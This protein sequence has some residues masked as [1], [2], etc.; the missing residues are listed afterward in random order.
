MDMPPAQRVL[1]LGAS[2]M[3]GRAVQEEACRADEL[4]LRPAFVS[5]TTVFW[6]MVAKPF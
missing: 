2:G 3:I 6:L 4:E 1:V 5:L